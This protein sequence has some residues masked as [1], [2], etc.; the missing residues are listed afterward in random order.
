MEELGLYIHI[1]FCKSKCSY[2]DFN[3]YSG[4]EYLQ[5]SYVDC[6][7]EEIERRL[8]LLDRYNINTI[9][10]GG[11]TPTYL[12]LK[13]FE[14]LLVYLKKY[15]CHGVEYTCESNP[16][17]LTAEKFI[18][19]KENGVNRLSIGLQ[20]WDDRILKYLGRIHDVE[21]FVK[22]YY[23][24][25]SAGFDNIN[26]DIMFAIQGQSIE[27]FK[28]TLD[29]LISLNPQHISCYS[30]IVEEGTPFGEQLKRGELKEVDEDTDRYMYHMAVRKL[31]EAG[32]EHYEISNFAKPEYKCRHN[33]IYWKTGAYIGIGAG[34]HSYVDG[35]RFSNEEAPEKY[36]SM[37]KQGIFPVSWEEKLSVKDM[38][39][40]YMFMGLRMM[41]GIDCYEFKNRFNNNIEDI[42]GSSIE[43]M[44]NNGLLMRNGNSIS[45]T[46][47]GIDI[48][49][50]VFCEFV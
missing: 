44:I 13:S 48:S 29:N 46:E 39:A 8:Y 10:I 34:A 38:M 26:V 23:D 22:N 9:F 49:N 43:A 47:R 27:C 33:I 35:V 19:M 20:S 41:D 4:L 17:T 37:I 25:R 21:Q 1:P 30:L 7:I 15:A 40:E 11:G 2:C 50:Q 42:Y 12:N 24:A 28:S 31:K 3:S 45:L 36:I 18:L 16:G 14:K 32:Y 5:D 6:I